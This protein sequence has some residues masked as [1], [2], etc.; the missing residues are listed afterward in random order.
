MRQRGRVE[1]HS[2]SKPMA[3]KNSGAVRPP[4]GTHPYALKLARLSSPM[5]FRDQ[6]WGVAFIHYMIVGALILSFPIAFYLD[7]IV[8]AASAITAAGA[9]CLV[10]VAPNWRQRPDPGMRWVPMETVY[11][12]YQELKAAR[13]ALN[14]SD[15]KLDIREMPAPERGGLKTE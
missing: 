7:S 5:S 8:V 12:Y 14:T 2:N 9:I 3:G 6:E 11:Q 4:T 13:Q 15:R 10:V 1:E